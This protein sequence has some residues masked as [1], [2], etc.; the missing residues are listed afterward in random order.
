MAEQ[1]FMLNWD[2][3]AVHISA[4]VQEW[5]VAKEIAMLPHLQYLPKLLPADFFFFPRVKETL[6]GLKMDAKNFRTTW[7]GVAAVGV[8]EEFA[9]AFRQ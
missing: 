3:A 6:S 9:A 1:G 7:N 5:L 4:A 8:A 2:N